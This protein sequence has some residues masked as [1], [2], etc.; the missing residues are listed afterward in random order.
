M[1]CVTWQKMNRITMTQ[2]NEASMRLTKQQQRDVLAALPQ[3]ARARTAEGLEVAEVEQ[4]VRQVRTDVKN[5]IQH[6]VTVQIT[7]EYQEL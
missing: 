5:A 6:G 4:C 7:P 1:D 2:R 3:E